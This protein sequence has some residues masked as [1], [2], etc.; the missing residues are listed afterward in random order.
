[1]S[2]AVE[3]IIIIDDDPVHNFISAR[4]IKKFLNSENLPIISFTS[5]HEG[6]TY[7]INACREKVKI[8]LFLDVNMPSF[9]GWDVLSELKKSVDYT[10]GILSVYILSSSVDP[11]DKERA[12]KFPMVS[13]YLVKPLFEHLPAIFGGA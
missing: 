5:P 3:K 6:I 10:E 13:G 11:D 8:L 7:I 2:P 9:S 12:Y 4:S 1:M